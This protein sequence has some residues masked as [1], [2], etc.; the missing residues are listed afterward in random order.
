M[1]VPKGGSACSKCR[2]LSEDSKH[3][4][5]GYFQNWRRSLG[6]EP[7]LIPAPADAYCCDVFASA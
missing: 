6:E 2:F 7:S 5:S 1:Q 3:C 4:G